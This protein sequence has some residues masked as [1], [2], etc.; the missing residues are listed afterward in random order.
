MMQ[1]EL[2]DLK[3]LPYRH[4][5]SIDSKLPRG[6]THSEHFKQSRRLPNLLTPERSS[7]NFLAGKENLWDSRK[8]QACQSLLE[9]FDQI[10]Y[11]Q[12]PSTNNAFFI[13]LDGE[14]SILNDVTNVS[15]RLHAESKDKKCQ[16]EKAT[17]YFLPLD[18]KSVNK[19]EVGENR[20]ENQHKDTKNLLNALKETGTCFY[21]GR[22]VNEYN[23]SFHNDAKCQKVVREKTFLISSKHDLSANDSWPKPNP[24]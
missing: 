22:G 21:C 1:M 10:E 18:L 5:D 23:K 12:K 20:N 3:T 17:G 16:I 13:P 24:S 2:P 19:N 9:K 15:S 11:S 14:T 4:N 7:S 8:Q 6:R